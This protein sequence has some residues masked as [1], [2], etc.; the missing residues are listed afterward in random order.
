[1]SP[2]AH[3][4]DPVG[5]RS[6]PYVGAGSEAGIRY[7][8]IGRSRIGDDLAVIQHPRGGPKAIALGTLAG[9]CNEQIYYTDLDTLVGSSGAGVLNDGG[10]VAGVHTDGDCGKDGSGFNRGW[11]AASI[12]AASAYLQDTDI[13]ER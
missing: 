8:G 10:Y 2:H 4:Q 5:S 12:V 7:R 13:A 9:A 3:A 1:M 11:S 6:D